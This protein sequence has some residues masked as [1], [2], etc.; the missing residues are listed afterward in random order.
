MGAQSSVEVGANAD[1]DWPWVRQQGVDEGLTRRLVGGA[2]EQLFELVDDEQPIGLAGQ[3]DG[4]GGA[5]G[6]QLDAG[7]PGDEAVLGG[8]DE[9]GAQHRGLA[10]AGRADQRQQ[11]SGGETVGE[12]GHDVL[13]T[14]EEVSVGG[15]EG[16]QAPVGALGGR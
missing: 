12:L 11:R 3:V 1:D 13:A 15:F 7:D 14:E 6:A 5:G 16:L 8:A 9:A 2:G 10:A 4:R